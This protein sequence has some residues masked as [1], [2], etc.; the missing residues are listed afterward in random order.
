LQGERSLIPFRQLGQYEDVETGLYYNRFR[1][2]S[3]ETGLYLSQDPIGLLGNNPNFY[4]YVHDSNSWVDV[5]GLYNGEGVR[6]LDAYHIFHNHQLNQSEYTLNDKEHFS[7]ANETLHKKFERHPEFAAKMEK[8]YP[9]ITK[10]VSPTKTGNY[11]GTAPKGTTWHHAT[12]SQTGGKAG[13]LQLVD[14]KDH[15]KY[16]KIYHPEDVG[17]RNQWGGGTGCR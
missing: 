16:H 9:G 4:A 14:M 17:G 2:Y 5:F 13:V 8:K 11:R 1:Y 12:T 7:K 10:H 3:P 6:D 15:S